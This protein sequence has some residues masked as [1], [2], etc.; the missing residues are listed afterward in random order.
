MSNNTPVTMS[1]T[2]LLHKY[3]AT[4]TLHFKLHAYMTKYMYIF[5]ILHYK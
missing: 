1:V 5:S 4:F 2:S 3:I